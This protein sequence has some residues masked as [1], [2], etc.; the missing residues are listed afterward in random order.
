M[1]TVVEALGSVLWNSLWQVAIIA[2]L[3]ALVRLLVDRR[4]ANA[5]Y[6]LGCVA[7]A[8][9]VVV[10]LATAIRSKP[11]SH[12]PVVSFRAAPET[13]LPSVNRL[14]I[15]TLEDHWTKPP[16]VSIDTGTTRK[17][18][19][20]EWAVAG[21]LI[22]VGVFS[23]RLLL[24]LQGARRLVNLHTTVVPD[25][26][27]CEASILAEC[28]GIK[29]AVTI[30]ASSVVKTPSVVGYFSPVI[31]LPASL[32]TGLPAD[33]LRSI[34]VHELAHIRRHDYLVNLIQLGI[35]TLLFYHPATWWVSRC[36]RRER[37][38]CCD[39]IVI[40]VDGHTRSYVPALLML[41]SMRAEDNVSVAATSGGSILERIERMLGTRPQ[42]GKRLT[43]L[44]LVAVLVFVGGAWLSLKQSDLEITNKDF[45]EPSLLNSLTRNPMPDPSHLSMPRPN[46]VPTAAWDLFRAGAEGDLPKIRDLV[47]ADPELMHYQFDYEIP[48]H[49]AVREGRYEA[50]DYFLEEGANPAFSNYTYS[51]WPAL[52]QIAEEGGFDRIH[53]RLVEEME[54]RFNYDPAYVELWDAIGKGLTEEVA[55][56]ISADPDLVH[57]ADGHGN[58]ALHW[59]VV[60]RRLP[61]I[62]NLL[63]ASADIQARRA[64]HQTPLHISVADDYWFGK[65]YQR[66]LDTSV[67]EVTN[68]LLSRGARYEFAVAAARG[69]Q[70]HVRRELATDPELACLLN[71]SRRSPLAFATQSGNLDLV[72]LL[73]KHGANPNLA[74]HC[75]DR[76]R[77]LFVASQRK[78]IAM[79]QLLLDHDAD[80]NAGV[81]SCGNCLSIADDESNPNSAEA[82]RI[83]RDHGAKEGDWVTQTSMLPPNHP[84]I[85]AVRDVNLSR[86]RELIAEDSSLVN[87]QVRGDIA[88]TGKVWKDTHVDVGANN[89]EHAGALHFAAFHG[90]SE[91]AQLL[92]DSG[93]DLHATSFFGEKEA[94]PATL[95]A[96]QGGMETL[97]VIRDGAKAA[98]IEL[99]LN[100]ALF[101]ALAHHDQETADLLIEYG[102]EHDIFT[103]AMAGDLEILQRL[104]EEDPESLNRRHEEYGRTPL[105]QA[106]MVGQMESAEL[107]AAKGAKVAPHAA[108]AMGRIDQVKAFLKEEP[109]AISRPFGK[110]PLLLW[111]I[112]GSQAD[113]VELLL[114]KGADPNGGDEWD[115]TPLRQVADV[116]GDV[117]ARIVDLLVEAGANLY[118]KS[119]GSTPVECAKGAKNKHVNHRLIYH[120]ENDVEVTDSEA[121]FWKAVG[122][123]DLETVK[124]S[125]KKNSSLASKRFPTHS[126]LYFLTDGLPLHLAA[127]KG[128]WEIAQLLM[129]HGADP[130]AKR[131]LDEAPIRGMDNEHRELGMPIIFAY[132]QR[133][134]DMVHHLLDKGASVH[135]HPYCAHP[136]AS[137]VYTDAT[138]AG[139]PTS[140]V[141]RSIPNLDEEDRNKIKPVPGDAPEVIKLY[142]RILTLGAIPDHGAI[143]QAGDFETVEMLLRKHPTGATKDYWGKNVHEALLYGS[144]W[145]GNARVVE[146]C[147]DICTDSHTT[148]AAQHCIRNAITSHNRPGTFDGYYRVI[149]L[150]L[151]YLKAH[152]AFDKHDGFLPLHCLADGFI[153]DQYYGPC[154]EPPNVEQQLKLAQ[155][156][157]DKGVHINHLTSDY[158]LTPLDHAINANQK[159]YA[160]FL[161]ENGGK[162]SKDLTS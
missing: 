11:A 6:L 82:M 79:I 38:H 140:M 88:L 76:G 118:E 26:V 17:M 81:D 63:G 64:D 133:N 2:L 98:G 44:S 146:M 155:L 31:L 132:G 56:L 141:L 37:E 134:F 111:A 83:L 125:L 68:L 29:H 71:E 99:D 127:A 148:Y 90:H 104:I 137:I 77:A 19:W 74:E 54:S 78:D 157:L 150:N 107:L 62:E 93:A 101:S 55:R 18:P 153:K 91:L 159:E 162:E 94:T 36:V 72:R 65:Q 145:R 138:A 110:Q 144:A 109:Q 85:V 106:L 154:P 66:N 115:I 97:K 135:A 69:D 13:I 35:E 45:R 20:K 147:M 136:F 124:A 51:S 52:L 39:D 143:A 89:P 161:R 80:P 128:H 158:K 126:D 23:T 10:P 117:G 75:A 50:V 114:E 28:L 70:E 121:A 102:A 131:D 22:G 95:A 48:L 112:Q 152:D 32:V 59:A 67:R 130:N 139:S 92:I 24:G 25:S 96:W 14:Q 53:Q 49:Y 40:A 73:L 47:E 3:Y 21:W 129:E 27:I 160:A 57:I 33:Q 87:A 105:E 84:F 41:E 100:P 103:A 30:L 116:K 12:A 61:I 108:A 120:I 60:A 8:A 149:E 151:D 15:D 1:E 119:R 42:P 113:V 58:R 16:A 122:E 34:L 4:H 7:L 46:G 156:C 43:L 9:M 86:V 142:D 123:G 5:R